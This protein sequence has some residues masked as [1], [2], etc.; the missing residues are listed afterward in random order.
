MPKSTTKSKSS[1]SLQQSTLSFSASK[2][3][4]SKDTQKVPNRAPARSQHALVHSDND[5]IDVDDE[6][7]EEEDDVIEV[8]DSD[9][10][11]AKV[12]PKA[13]VPKQPVVVKVTRPREKAIP[14]D[15]ELDEKD[16][17]W[18][19]VYGASK[20]R[21]GNLQLIHAEDQDKFH[22]ILRVFD[23]S[24][25][26][27]PCVGVT[28]LERWERAFALGLDPPTEDIRFAI[29]SPRAKVHKNHTRIPCFTLKSNNDP[30]R[31]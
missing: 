21:R 23:L 8:I 16:K 2:R 4:G 10:P 25:E 28:R 31:S 29:F 19:S 3:T 9:E 7:S 11:N 12:T 14:N 1:A 26:Y 6:S 24:Y 13:A 27:G 18:R 5:T 15:L 22:D 30:N 17:R 20:T